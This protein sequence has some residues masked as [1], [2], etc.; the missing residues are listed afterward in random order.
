MNHD[1]QDY[2]GLL[3]ALR[4]HESAEAGTG[5]ISIDRAIQDGR[6]T[7]RRRRVLGGVAVVALIAAA[8][9]SPLLLRDQDKV[10]P[11]GPPQPPKT[12]PFSLWSRAFE[13][14]TAGGFT[15][16]TYTTGRTAQQI[17]LRP[18]PRPSATRPLV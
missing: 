7:V 10:E 18:A 16:S 5:G 4:S 11:I 2:T 6:R 8:S 9:T 12:S 13:A 14:E 1:D 15:P 17:R 3:E